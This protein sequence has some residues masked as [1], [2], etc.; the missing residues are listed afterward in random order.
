MPSYHWCTIICSIHIGQAC[1]EICQA[2]KLSIFIS[3]L[4]LLFSLLCC[5]VSVLIIEVACTCLPASFGCSWW[6]RHQAS[7]TICVRELQKTGEILWHSVPWECSSPS[8]W[9]EHLPDRICMLPL[10][11]C[12]HL[13]CMVSHLHILILFFANFYADICSNPSLDPTYEQR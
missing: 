12:R 1:S 10:H 5:F 13:L 6:Y 7:A 4:L 3:W 2:R 9:S 8:P 11:I